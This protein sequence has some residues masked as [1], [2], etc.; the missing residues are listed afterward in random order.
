[1]FR[2]LFARKQVSEPK[3]TLA[4]VEL[5][6]TQGSS[7]DVVAK[8]LY[9][10]LRDDEGYL[11]TNDTQVWKL[12][13]AYGSVRSL[14]DILTFRESIKPMS[15]QDVRRGYQAYWHQIVSCMLRGYVEAGGI[16]NAS[17]AIKVCRNLW[18]YSVWD[19][20]LSHIEGLVIKNAVSLI[21]E[22]E[23]ILDFALALKSYDAKMVFSIALGHTPS[24]TFEEVIQQRREDMERQ[25]IEAEQRLTWG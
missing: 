16:K 12:A 19:Y 9:Q 1:M 25:R 2:R 14:D 13:F 17:D 7:P 4:D 20:E 5:L 23:D 10:S 21:V 11:R 15:E 18:G 22:R 24:K 6:I 3:S 8:A